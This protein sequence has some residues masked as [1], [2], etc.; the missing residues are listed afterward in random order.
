RHRKEIGSESGG[1][2][3]RRQ[4]LPLGAISLDRS[5]AALLSE[6]A[7]VL[8]SL[9]PAICLPCRRH[10][11]SPCRTIPA[12]SRDRR[13]QRRRSA[14]PSSPPRWRGPSYADCWL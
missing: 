3:E 13:H 5:M 10:L 1:S 11:G 9:R 2:K 8:V 7:E 14:Q 6:R 4:L 12:R